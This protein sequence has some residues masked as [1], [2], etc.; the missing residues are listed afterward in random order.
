MEF[1]GTDAKEFEF[2]KNVDVSLLPE[3]L[4]QT[5]INKATQFEMTQANII[6]NVP[7]RFFETTFNDIDKTL[8]DKV[9]SFCLTQ[10]S[11]RIFILFG[12]VGLG[13]TSAMAASIHERKIK[14]MDCGLYYSI[15]FLMP[16]LRNCRSYS[17]QENE[18][19]FYKRLSEVSYLCLDEVGTC[20]VIAEE[21]EFLTTVLAAR[22]DNQ[23][24]TFIATNLS[25][26]E[27]KFLI[28]G[29]NSCDKTLEEQKVLCQKLDKES[30][31]LNRI[32]SVAIPYILTGES[33]RT[34]G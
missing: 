11:D 10:K 4:N 28:T 33:Y 24:P 29:V 7:K 2:F 23:L 12:N 34:R 31:I 27:F 14:D 5:P 13:K 26:Y 21:K 32:K 15:R 30:A 25:P 9:K 19:Q 22:F 18:L 16:T 17:A 20:P 6:A 1:N 3:E 8:A